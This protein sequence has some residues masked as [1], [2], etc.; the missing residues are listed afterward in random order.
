MMK[1]IQ[2]FAI[3]FIILLAISCKRSE[4]PTFNKG[5]NAVRFPYRT[6]D[7]GNKEPVGFSEER[8]VFQ[9]N[10][11]FFQT[12][13]EE[14]HIVSIPLYL[15]GLKS[16]RDRISKVEV[17]EKETTAPIGSYELIEALI[18]ANDSVGH[19]KVKVFNIPQLKEGQLDLALRLLDSPELL[20]GP[21]RHTKAILSWS[22]R[23]PRPT[24]EAYFT[25]YNSIIDGSSS[26]D[27][28][29]DEYFSP[30]AL[31][32]IVKAL[33]W[34]DLDDKEKYPKT[35]NED[36]YKYLMHR[37]NSYK[38]RVAYARTVADYIEKYNR[39]NP[40]T[41]LLHDAG[42]LKGQP[43]KARSY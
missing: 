30:N 39:E 27:A 33:G 15:I 6:T 16:N 3:P 7:K 17:V 13:D 12:P 23:L 1:T 20:A 31:E 28:T 26:S 18:P 8:D 43:V 5:Y 29:T 35:Y 2:I 41:P 14:S 38:G 21:S 22:I 42:I 19:L 36:G 40:A 37:T 25:T 32:T 34:T 10:Y 4:I 24:N 11:S 9:K